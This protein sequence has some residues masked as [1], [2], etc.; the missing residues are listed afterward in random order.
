MD[1]NFLQRFATKMGED[2][3][4]HHLH[5]R[6]EQGPL[7]SNSLLTPNNSSSRKFSNSTNTNR[8]GQN[9]TPS[10]RSSPNTDNSDS[11]PLKSPPVH[12]SL[13]AL[14]DESIVPEL[15]RSESGGS[16]FYSNG[17]ALRRSNS[18]R[19]R[20]VEEELVDLQRQFNELKERILAGD[21]IIRLDDENRGRE[22][23]KSNGLRRRT[24]SK[25]GSFV[26]PN[27]KIEEK[28]NSKSSSTKLKLNLDEDRDN[29]YLTPFQK[30]N[31]RNGKPRSIGLAQF[32][33][34]DLAWVLP[35][36]PEGL[37]IDRQRVSNFLMVPLE[38]E[39]L[40]LFG[41]FVCLDTML[42]VFTF[43]PLRMFVALFTVIGSLFSSFV[44]GRLFFGYGTGRRVYAHRYHLYDIFR[45][46]L[47]LI[48]C[49]ALQFV[50]MSRIYHYIR[51]QSV[52]KLYL[53]FGMLDIFDRLF[54]ALGQDVLQS[55]YYATRYEPRHKFRTLVQFLF[56]QAYVLAHSGLKFVQLVT[57]TVAIN[58]TSNA[59]LTLLISNNFTEMKSLVFKRFDESNVFQISCADVVE[60]FVLYVFLALVFVQNYRELSLLSDMTALGNYLRVAAM[61]SFSEILVDCIKH[62]F[63]TKFNG[64]SAY[65]YTKYAKIIGDDLAASRRS[66]FSMETSMDPTH[67]VTQRLGLASFPL[68]CVIVRVFTGQMRGINLLNPVGIL[69]LGCTFSCLF[70][71]KVMFSILLLVFCEWFNRNPTWSEKEG[72]KKNNLSAIK[73][74]TL[75]GSKI[76][77]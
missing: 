15:A 63:I 75:C 40:Q 74:F 53:L 36:R 32:I 31:V 52:I 17:S 49:Y 59:V 38:L 3:A 71:I 8:K 9:L 1:Q 46:A 77:A 56:A 21:D 72:R 42:F 68:A 39:K 16:H 11:F 47:M 24:K 60:R 76:P 4:S 20:A 51:T 35:G 57:L 34:A 18:G 14:Q 27:G 65:S 5:N 61:I 26:T 58:S 10:G 33:G 41:C 13:G 62:A 37:D 12:N 7:E 70:L 66:E 48:T 23:V 64:L 22:N 28:V 67:S 2:S 30:S 6:Y 54:T 25:D 50:H 43:L 73:R 55:L 19:F 45:G 29:S 44:P 69:L